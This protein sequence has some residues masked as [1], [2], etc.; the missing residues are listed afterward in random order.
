MLLEIRA[1]IHFL[2]LKDLPN[3]EI[4]RQIDSIYREAVIGFRAT[5]NLTHRF[6][7]GDHCLEDEHKAS[8][9]G[10]TEYMNAI[11]ALLADDP[12]LS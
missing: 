4:S 1:I 10:L 2:W 5:Q 3:V 11:P 12:Y 9:P 6:A 7:E 8:P